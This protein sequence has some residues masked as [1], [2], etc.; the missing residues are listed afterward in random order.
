M[1]FP[2]EMTL[3]KYSALLKTVGRCATSEERE[4]QLIPLRLTGILSNKSHLTII[5]AH[6]KSKG[7]RHPKFGH[8]TK[9]AS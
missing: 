5:V 1:P 2:I 6:L 3:A 7:Q 4:R 8:A 9:S